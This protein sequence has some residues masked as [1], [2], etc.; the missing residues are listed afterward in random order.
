MNEFK[1]NKFSIKGFL[2][3]EEGEEGGGA[4]LTRIALSQQKS[5]HTILSNIIEIGT[6]NEGGI[7]RNKKKFFDEK[8][9]VAKLENIHI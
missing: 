8:F 5:L 9:F 3:K 1:L 4:N 2:S 6:S 7:K